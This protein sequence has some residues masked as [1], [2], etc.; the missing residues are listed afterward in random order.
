VRKKITQYQ[1]IVF[2]IFST[3]A[4][5]PENKN[6][7]NNLF[8]TVG[9]IISFPFNLIPGPTSIPD[10]E[11]PL[12]L[13]E[14]DLDPSTK[15][16]RTNQLK[17]RFKRYYKCCQRYSDS[18]SS[19]YV[20][21]GDEDLELQDTFYFIERAFLENIAATNGI[22]S[23][24]IKSWARSQQQLERSH[25]TLWEEWYAKHCCVKD[26]H[27]DL[28]RKNP[29]HQAKICVMLFDWKHLSDNQKVAFC[30]GECFEWLKEKEND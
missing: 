25:K 24:K 27:K 30:E 28:P 10:V 4:F 26:G 3:V 14:V 2:M 16:I 17:S 9:F 18:D 19:L 6:E 8:E 1:A 5:A 20:S 15:C 13:T 11:L 7:Q 29:S 21:S 23:D 12:P 22:S